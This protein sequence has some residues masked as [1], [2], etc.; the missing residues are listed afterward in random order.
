MEGQLET[1]RAWRAR[2]GGYRVVAAGACARAAALM[3]PVHCCCY[4][5]YTTQGLLNLLYNEDKRL[6]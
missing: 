1:W 6:L 3:M 2:A 4:Y 5:S